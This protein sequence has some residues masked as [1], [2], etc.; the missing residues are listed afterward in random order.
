VFRGIIAATVT[1]MNRHGEVDEIS[2]RKY[3]RW[4]VKQGVH[5]VAVNVDTGEGPSLTRQE[6]LRVLEV[7]KGEVEGKALLVVGLTGL[8][9][10]R[11]TVEMATELE[12]RGAEAFLVFPIAAFRGQPQSPEVV[13]RY[14]LAIADA[15]SVPL[16]AFQLQDGLGGVE[17]SAESLTRLYSIPRVKAIKEAAFDARKFADLLKFT[18]A[19][20]YDVAVLTGNDNFIFES[21]MLGCDGALIGF[22]TL[23]SS[24][25]VEMY[26]AWAAGDVRRAM[27]R[28]AVI[29]PLA[30]TI[31]APPVR[32][33]RARTKEALV[34]QG[35][36]A[37]AH[38][39]APLLPVTDAER[40]RVRL[41][42]HR[43]GLL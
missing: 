37:E 16:I 43:A 25:Q 22:G 11:A 19:G 8:G 31:F 40:E 21:F 28:G 3:M 10:T 38:V 4:L 41:A 30:D 14:H 26:Q 12:R 6:Q 27:E 33:Y 7:V 23:A 17:F 36:I 42:L 24:L 20:G 32:D 39:R 1:P 34:M 29:Q 15:V 5:G 35:V 9:S 18:R 2:L 13:Y